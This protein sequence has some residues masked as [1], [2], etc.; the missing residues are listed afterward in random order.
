MIGIT[1]SIEQIRAAPPEVRRWIEHEVIAA[2]G[3]AAA[4]PA[5][6]PQASASHLVACTQDDVAAV[7]ARIQRYLPAVNVLFEFSRPGIS[8]GQPPLMQFRLMDILHH[9]RLQNIGRV[10]E[11]LDAINRALAEV[12]GDPTLRFC[13]FD[14]E[15]HCLIVPQTQASVAAVWQDTTSAALEDAG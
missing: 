2:L 12:R 6:A 7:L 8:M 1:L 9:T 15:G 11:C 14:H 4:A 5:A 13:G 3:I 10:I